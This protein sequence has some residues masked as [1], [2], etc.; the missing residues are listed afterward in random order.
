MGDLGRFPNLNV[1]WSALRVGSSHQSWSNLISALTLSETR[2]TRR[3][4]RVHT[5]FWIQH[6]CQITKTTMIYDKIY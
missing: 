1:I 3:L 5:R 6:A 2:H 4:A